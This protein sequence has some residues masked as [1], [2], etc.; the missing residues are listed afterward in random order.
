MNPTV[1]CIGGTNLDRKM[2]LSQP[3][4]MGSSNPVSS[5][6]SC[7]GVA[8]N[9]AENLVRLGIKVVLLSIFSDDLEGNW[10][11]DQTK[12][13]GIDSSPSIKLPG[14]SSGSYTTLNDSDGEMLMAMADMQIA[15]SINVDQLETIWKT[16]HLPDAVFLDTNFPKPVIQWIIDQ[17]RKSSLELHV[18]PVSVAKTLKLPESLEGIHTLHPN[19][20]E[21][22]S[23]TR[24]SLSSQQQQIDACKHLL[25]RGVKHVV[26]SLGASGIVWVGEDTLFSLPAKRLKAQDVTGAGDALC[27]GILWGHL[28]GCSKKTSSEAGMMMAAKTMESHSSVWT[29]LQPSFLEPLLIKENKPNHAC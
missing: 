22:E 23:L 2:K 15:D 14:K 26:L 13:M 5:Q 24:N 9:V 12:S 17:C 1:L 18:D 11:L 10:L 6:I 8:R 4:R 27:A 29:G 20:A 25:H 28:M 3:L 19:L 16:I 7:G 21:L